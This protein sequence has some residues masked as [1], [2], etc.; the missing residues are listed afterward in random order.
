MKLIIIKKET[1][2]GL[3]LFQF[4]RESDLIKNPHP[5]TKKRTKAK[6][7][8]RNVYA[9]TYYLE[10]EVL[11]CSLTNLAKNLKCHPQ[12]VVN[13]IKKSQIKLH[14]DLNN[15]AYVSMYSLY[16]IAEYIVDSLKISDTIKANFFT[17][18][19]IFKQFDVNLDFKQLLEQED[20]ELDSQ[21]MSLSEDKR[22]TKYPRRV[23]WKS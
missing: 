20:F 3:I 18:W 6:N 11:G 23:K 5:N 7:P 1:K 10:S 16:K 9:I 12:T 14:R 19:L 21:L 15:V 4:C 17:F 13:I 22:P 2:K 8:Y